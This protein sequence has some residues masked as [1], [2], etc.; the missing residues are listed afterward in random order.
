MSIGVKQN[1]PAAELPY[2]NSGKT[3]EMVVDFRRRKPNFVG[4]HP[5]YDVGD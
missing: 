2:L 5:G 3:K 4:E 1:C